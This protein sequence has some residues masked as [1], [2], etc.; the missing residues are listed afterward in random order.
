MNKL[1]VFGCSISDLYDSESSIKHWYSQ[2]YIDWKG[3]VP[4][5]HTQI[6]AEKL[7]CE[8]VNKA[9]SASS[10]AQIFQDFCDNV[11]NIKND[12]YV[13]VQWSD[14]NR[15]RFV[16]D[17]D[18]WIQFAFQAQWIQHKLKKFSHIKYN[19]IQ[20]VLSNRLTT[21]KYFEEVLSWENLIKRAFPSSNILIWK[22]FEKVM[23]KNS[24]LRSVELIKDETKNE[25]IDY[26]FSEKGQIQISKILI[27]M[28]FNNS[29]NI[30]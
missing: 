20:E 15:T 11:K 8:L 16:N 29:K 5:H 10:N 14:T 6:I 19:T 7:G 12:D 24:L 4:T 2:E 26:H 22:P 30:I 3:Y 13:I 25:I 21:E 23:G 18:E 9:I 17:D 27:D 28:M 1:W